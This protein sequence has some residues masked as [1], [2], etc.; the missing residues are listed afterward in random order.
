MNIAYKLLLDIRR[1]N[2]KY[3]LNMSQYDDMSRL[4]DIILMD[5]GVALD[6]SDVSTAKFKSTYVVDKQ[7]VIFEDF[8]DIVKDK[9]GNN[10]NEIMFTIPANLTQN[11]VVLNCKVELNGIDS[12][13]VSFTLST[14]EFYISIENALYDDS[15]YQSGADIQALNNLINESQKTLEN[16]RTTLA[17]VEAKIAEGIEPFTVGNVVYD[18]KTPKTVESL[19][20]PFS[21]TI[22]DVTYDGSQSKT[23]NALKNPFSLT[24]DD[25]VY[26]GSAE[27]TIKSVPVGAIRFFKDSVIADP[28]TV[29]GGRWEKVDALSLPAERTIPYRGVVNGY[30]TTAYKIRANVP[31]DMAD[32]YTEFSITATQFAVY[33]LADTSSVDTNIFYVGGNSSNV[34]SLDGYNHDI[35]PRSAGCSVYFEAGAVGNF[36]SGNKLLK[37]NQ[38]VGIYFDGTVTARGGAGVSAWVKLSN[39]V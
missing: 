29:F 6:M 24:I 26:D 37:G 27:K 10:M 36:K 14:A 32:K 39:E 5:D 20:N 18:G 11:A 28:S 19:K 3:I 21:L 4:I 23:A 31:F 22:G 35:E 7:T 8:C 30:A 16:V 13:E 12:S 34:P 15:E 17:E 2:K 38:A 33:G 1:P 25:V 9:E